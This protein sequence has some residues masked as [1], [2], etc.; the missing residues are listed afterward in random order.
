MH[1]ML[2]HQMRVGKGLGAEQATS[3][4][5]IGIA[6]LRLSELRTGRRV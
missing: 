5:L 1:L 6:G 2:V 3:P 4:K